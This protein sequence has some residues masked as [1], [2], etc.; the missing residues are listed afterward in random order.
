MWNLPDASLISKVFVNNNVICYILSSDFFCPFV[1]MLPISRYSSCFSSF[2]W[3]A[4]LRGL[5]G[6][7]GGQQCA[8]MVSA[9]TSV[10]RGQAARCWG[11]TRSPPRN[12]RTESYFLLYL[13]KYECQ[14]DENQIGCSWDMGLS[15]A[16]LQLSMRHLYENF[17]WLEL[18]GPQFSFS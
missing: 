10:S 3:M 7:S 9:G 6:D 15:S 11:A 2:E 8:A 17:L 5:G 1:R 12:Q 14:C 13:S 16:F 18:D 4:S